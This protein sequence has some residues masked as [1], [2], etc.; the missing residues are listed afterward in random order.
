MS[1][2]AKPAVRITRRQ[3][4][5]LGAG[6]LVAAAGG[7]WLPQATLAAASGRGWAILNG[8]S[9]RGAGHMAVAV[10]GATGEYVF[11]SKDGFGEWLYSKITMRRLTEKAMLDFVRGAGYTDAKYYSVR[12]PDLPAASRTAT[13]WMPRYSPAYNN[14]L[15]YTYLILRAYGV[16]NLP[17]PSNWSTTTPRAWFNALGAGWTY[18][19]P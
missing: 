3:L 11:L 16:P 14:C 6:G 2:G 15:D 5:K 10:Q 7:L 8:N 18:K 19:K 13:E 4:V 17:S 9:L 12:N 1:E